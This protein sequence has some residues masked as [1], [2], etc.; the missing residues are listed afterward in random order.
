MGRGTGT[1]G[2]DGTALRRRMTAAGKKGREG[3]HME[4]V[5][6]HN[7]PDDAWMVFGGRVYDVSS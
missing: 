4:E 7:T 1:G 5:A 6:E 3:I 2:K